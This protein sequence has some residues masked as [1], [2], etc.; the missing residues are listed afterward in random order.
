MD[1]ALQLFELQLPK[2]ET[3]GLGRFVTDSDVLN[4][5]RRSSHFIVV[6]S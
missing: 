6:P 3:Y 2:A 5:R 1:Y 4:A